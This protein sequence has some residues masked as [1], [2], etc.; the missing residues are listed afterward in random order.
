MVRWH[1]SAG[2]LTHSVPLS[3]RDIHR[4]LIDCGEAAVDVTVLSAADRLATLGR[5]S[6]EAIARHLEV[7]DVLLSAA[8]ERE[9]NGDPEPLVRGDVLADALGIEPG[10]ILG[11]AL[12]E[13]A[14]ARYA[15]EVE[16]EGEAI[17]HASSWVQAQ[18]DLS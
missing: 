10:Q 6:E 16:T 4:Y 9:V 5:H 17:D 15:G 11:Q 13:I 3:R 14:S 8:V 7:V 2:F 12:A 1:L 18:A